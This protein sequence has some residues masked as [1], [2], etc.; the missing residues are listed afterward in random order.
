MPPHV[1][2]FASPIPENLRD[3]SDPTGSYERERVDEMSGAHTPSL[4]ATPLAR[5]DLN[6]RQ[7]KSPLARGVPD[8]SAVGSA[9]AEGRGVLAWSTQAQFT[10]VFT[11]HIERVDASRFAHS[12]GPQN[13]IGE[14]KL[15]RT[16][17]RAV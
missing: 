8:V 1:T 7:L 6:L 13:S 4:R 12:A 15:R 9:K 14:I 16:V 5:G 10:R 2:N 17:R 11:P 3:R